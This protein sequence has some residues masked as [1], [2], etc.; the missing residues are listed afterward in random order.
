MC[1]SNPVMLKMFVNNNSSSWYFGEFSLQQ[2]I[3]RLKTIEVSLF[4]NGKFRLCTDYKITEYRI[5][6]ILFLK[7][8]N[9]FLHSGQTLDYK[10][11]ISLMR[12][13]REFA[14]ETKK[15][16]WAGVHIE[17]SIKWI[18]YL[19]GQNQLVQFYNKLLERYWRR[20]FSYRFE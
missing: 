7:L 6:N 14:D 10:H 17:K 1:F 3:I 4:Q 5:S 2:N 12:I 15:N 16:L 19:S 18:D 11:Y 9:F 20:H 13:V 8:N